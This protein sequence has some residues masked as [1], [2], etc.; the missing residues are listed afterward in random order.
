[1]ANVDSTPESHSAKENFLYFHQL[2]S[3][4]CI[5]RA[6]FFPVPNLSVRIRS[7][8]SSADFSTCFPVCRSVSLVLYLQHLVLSVIVLR[9][10]V[11]IPLKYWIFLFLSGLH[12]GLLMMK[13][14]NHDVTGIK[15]WTII[16]KYLQKWRFTSWISVLIVSL[17]AVLLW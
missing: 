5:C 16:L 4:N 6:S 12:D 8:S 17:V 15:W 7:R 10:S 11:C 9:L 1:M 13:Y 2:K 3:C 14:G